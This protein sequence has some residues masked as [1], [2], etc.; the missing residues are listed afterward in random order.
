MR[1]TKED[2]DK[3]E[4]DYADQFNQPEAEPRQM[5]DEE[6]FGLTPETNPADEAASEAPAAT[7]ESPAEEAAEPAAEEAAE[8][9][10]EEAA[11]PPAEEAAEQAAGTEQPS[12]EESAPSAA[13]QEQR[14]RSWE[15]RLKARQAE[16]DAREAAMSNSS[17]NDEQSSTPAGEGG[18]GGEASAAAEGGSEGDPAQV[19][20]EDFGSD[21]VQQL[22]KLIQKVAG[23]GYNDINYKVGCI[24]ND[25]Q[26]ER[27]QN[28]FSAIAAAHKDFM[29]VVE[30][31]EFEAW[32]A[33]QPNQDQIAQVIERGS[34]QQI[35]DMLSAFK[36][37][38]KA[39][40]GYGSDHDA[41]LDAAEGVRS[42]AAITLPK[43]PA[44]DDEFAK[45]W[46]EA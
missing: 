13:D 27:L 26:N 4:A 31:P 12:A 14:L 17:V 5:S 30:S 3:N 18:E 25:L 38:R 10:A 7:A 23:E 41:A 8:T 37:S 46:N 9:P 29:D 11:E 44:P 32:K 19:L 16:L 35:I 6:A 40:E 24:L 45:A 1:M 42:G 36:D 39:Q 2:K 20:A 43:E 33:A 15:G 21:F 28:H 22:T 34:A